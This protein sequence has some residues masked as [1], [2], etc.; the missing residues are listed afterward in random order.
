MTDTT[1]TS[2]ACTKCGVVKPLGEFGKTPRGKYGV[3]AECNICRTTRQKNYAINNQEITR[4]AYKNWYHKNIE[5]VKENKA[6][7]YKENRDVIQPK[8]AAHQIKT[9]E[10]RPGY[11]LRYYRKNTPAIKEKAA[12]RAKLL[13]DSYVANKLRLPVSQATPELIDAKRWEITFKRGIKAINQAQTQKASK[14]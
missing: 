14:S 4:I 8:N 11:S 1:P 7:S 13:T 10:K 3:R 6:K 2:K 9:A 12:T 5:R